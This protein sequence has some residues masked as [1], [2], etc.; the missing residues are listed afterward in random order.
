VFL[1]ETK[2]KSMKVERLRISIGFD[3]MFHV[4]PIGRSGGLVMLWK[5]AK[6]VQIMNYHNGIS[7]P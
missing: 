5:Y 3:G 4:D 1:I 7:W 2:V 6:E